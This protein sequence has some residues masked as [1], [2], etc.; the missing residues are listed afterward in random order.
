M[1]ME[2]HE[3]NFAK[4]SNSEVS[5]FGLPY[6]FES[7]M[8]YG[9][10]FFTKNDKIT[11]ETLD[12]SKQD[13]IG[14][15]TGVS[16]GDIMLVKRMYNCN[17]GTSPSTAT[18]QTT[19]TT[20]GTTAGLIDRVEGDYVQ[21]SPPASNEWHYV[22][23]SKKKENVFT[24]K[25]KAGVEWDLVLS[26]DESGG[27]VTFKVGDECLYKKDGYTEARLYAKGDSIVIEGPGGLFTK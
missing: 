26:G 8:H 17:D 4:Q 9:A 3:D 2:G 19:G 5:Q 15:A 24:W 25:N 1:G 23:I 10:Y 13:I 12:P 16:K 21:T 18:P 11:I 7:V 27:R 14:H 22:R 20:T 6:D